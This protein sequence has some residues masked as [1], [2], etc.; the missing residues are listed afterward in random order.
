MQEVHRK[1]SSF[2]DPLRPPYVPS[3][4]GQR[5]SRCLFQDGDIRCRR[6][7]CSRK[8]HS[9]VTASVAQLFSITATLNTGDT[10]PLSA[11]NSIGNSI[12]RHRKRHN[13]CHNRRAKHTN[14]TGSRRLSTTAQPP[15]VPS[16][17]RSTA[18]LCH[19]NRLTSGDSRSYRHRKLYSTVTASATTVSHKPP[20]FI[21]EIRRKSACFHDR[22]ATV[23]LTSTSGQRLSDATQTPAPCVANEPD[24][25]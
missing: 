10:H 15:Y 13:V 17:S 5:R 7:T 20:R 19:S 23:Y 14:N 6:S 21:Q 18:S 16:T 11:K 25:K 1:S 24:R 8:W 3:T 9:T 4:S 2:H 22:S 12:P